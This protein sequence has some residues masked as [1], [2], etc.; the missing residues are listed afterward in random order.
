MAGVGAGAKGGKVG[1][2]YIAMAVHLVAGGTSGGSTLVEEGGAALR[3][4]G[5]HQRQYF[6]ELNRLGG[7]GER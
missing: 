7:R 1:S 3:V 2:K 4:G 6:G 5:G